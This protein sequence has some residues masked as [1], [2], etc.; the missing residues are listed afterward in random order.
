MPTVDTPHFRTN[1][2]HQ[3]PHLH[4][5]PDLQSRPKTT[6]SDISDLDP[7]GIGV[8]EESS[9]AEKPRTYTRWQ[10]L[11][12]Y[13]T[14]FNKRPESLGQK[15]AWLLK[16]EKTKGAGWYKGF[17]Q[18]Y[19]RRL[20]DSSKHHEP[21]SDSLSQ[22]LRKAS[23]MED[24]MESIAKNLASNECTPFYL[25]FYRAHRLALIPNGSALDPPTMPLESFTSLKLQQAH[26]KMFV[27]IRT[28]K[29][30]K[31]LCV[32]TLVEASDPCDS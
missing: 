29:P 2:F 30:R 19:K 3:P 20:R 22:L 27:G 6:S 25:G 31:D 12:A 14:E 23:G 18:W 13:E 7:D 32:F 11:Q 24:R 9:A 28:Q 10:L 17:F 21:T 16:L 1:E 26:M 8:G 4:R 15:A 5:I